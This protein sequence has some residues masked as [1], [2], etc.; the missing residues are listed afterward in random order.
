M[1]AKAPG[2]LATCRLAA[3]PGHPRAPTN[4]VDTLLVEPDVEFTGF[5]ADEAANFD[6][7]DPPLRHEPTNMP[8]RRAE[9]LGHA[10]GIQ[11]RCP[12][13]WRD[14]AL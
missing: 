4:D 9:D 8:G 11:Q 3:G 2:H 10:V 12:P 14:P 1:L 7:W 6:E 13:G 5:E